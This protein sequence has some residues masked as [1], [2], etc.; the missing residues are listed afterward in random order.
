MSRHGSLIGSMLG[1]ALLL[2][3]C[4]P[5]KVPGEPGE[6]PVAAP[7]LQSIRLFNKSNIQLA[8]QKPMADAAAEFVDQV[9]ELTGPLDQWKV[10]SASQGLDGQNHVRMRQFHQGVRVWGADIVAH[11]SASQVNMVNGAMVQNLEGF[12]V[13]PSLASEKAL[14]SAKADYAKGAKS[15]VTTLAYARESTELVIL[16]STSHEARLAWHVVFFTELQSGLAPS[17]SNYFIDAHTGEIIKRWNGIHTLSQASGA[18]GNAKVART[19][20]SALDVEPSGSLFAMD[21]ARLRTLNMNNGSS[22][23]TVVTGSLA[24]IGDA[25]INDAHGFA[26]ATLN[27]L[28]EWGGYNSIN[29]AGFKIISRVHYGSSYENAFWDGAQMTYGDGASTFYPLSGDVDVV[30][31]EIHHGFTTFHSDLVYSSQSGGMNESFSD[32]MG[33]AA[34]YFIE[35][36]SA[37]WDLGRDIFRGNTALR[38][39]CNPTQDGSSIDNLANYSEGIDVHYSSGI[40][41]KAFCRAAKRLGSG[42]PDGAATVA[43]VQKLAKAFYVANDNYWTSNSTFVQGCQG[44]LDATAA[45]NWTAAE[46]DILRLS[47]SES[48]VY[49]DGMVEPLICDETLTAASGTLTS[50]NY[51]NQYTNN[52]KRTWCIQPAGGAAATLHFTAFN[53]EAGYDFVEIK[54]AAGQQV[55]RTAGTTA[56]ADVT[57]TIIAVKFTSDSSQTRTGFSAT[58]STGGAPNNPPTVAI[59]SPAAGSQVSGAVAVAATASDDGSVARVR[60]ELPDG[61]SSEDT[62]APYGVSWN[63]TTVADGPSYTIR[64]TAYDN[65]GVASTPA[66]VAVSVRNAVGCIDGTFPATGLPLSIPDNNTTGITSSL[67]VSGTGNIGTLALSLNIAHT[68]RGDLIVTLTSPTGT[69]YTVH[70]RTGGSADNLVLDAQAISAFNG[71][72]AAGTWR[73]VVTDRA[74]S[75]TGAL[76]SWSLR[77]VGSCA[78]QT[79]WSASGSPNLALVDNGQACTTLNVTGTG[80]AAAAK[81]DISGT[82]SWRSVLRGTLAHNGTT[83]AAFPVSTFPSNSGAYSFT[84]RAVAGLSGSA[85]GAWTLCIIDNDAYGDTGTLATWSIHN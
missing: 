45:L 67:A 36:A 74:G 11:A 6:A 80:D 20:T 85:A 50:P 43:S 33:T 12:D 60:F 31:H 84:N 28:T 63:S 78:P 81:L 9:E 25:P 68:Y 51:P 29:N 18:G 13:E 47:W 22:G 10:R 41:N 14:A 4:G 53:T 38:F 35:G 34:E 70:N 83:V 69:A 52:Y 55:S 3:A 5:T 30:S 82:H 26:E 1:S 49:C 23:G 48:G 58:W 15:I 8:A 77:I 62:T 40:M 76:T 61:T 2:A 46:R 64:A 75:D 72:A 65:L 44:T 7:E 79:G 24:A 59:T 42:S 54:N 73:L 57:S 32:I 56:P 17:L 21:T 16:P 19:W 39:M 71:Q 37:D 27:M 66:T